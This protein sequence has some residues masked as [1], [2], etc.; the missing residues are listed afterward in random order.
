M[1]FMN[2]ILL[3]IFIFIISYDIY[4]QTYG[5]GVTD[6]DGNVYES[7]IIGQQEWMVQNLRVSRYSDGSQLPYVEDNYTWSNL[8]SPAWCWYNNDSSNDSLYGKIYTFYVGADTNTKNICPYRW[9]VPNDQEWLTL[10][11]YL[12]DNGHY[13][14]EGLVLKSTSGW[15]D[16]NGTDNYGFKGLPGGF[17]NNDGVFYRDNYGYY[18]CI[19]K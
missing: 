10:I 9:H 17:R 3:L 8:Y 15:G 4:A 1:L 18:G 16:G 14:Q 6:I 5:N 12:G 11:N 13:A 2:K 7:V 19:Q